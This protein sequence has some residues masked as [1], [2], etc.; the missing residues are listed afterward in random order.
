[1]LIA[2][3]IVVSMENERDSSPGD[4]VV[5]TDEEW[6]AGRTQVTRDM[7]NH[8]ARYRTPVFKDHGDHGEGWG[9]GSF[10]EING[11]KYILTNEHVATTRHSGARLGFQLADQDKLVLVQGDHVE[12]A[13]PLDLALLPVSEAGWTSLKHGSRAI[14]ADQIAAAHTA[15]P[16]EIF[17]F[18][19]FAGKGSFHFDTLLFRATTSVSREVELPADT[20]WDSRLHFGLDYRPDLAT[21]VVGNDGLPN[22]RGFSG[23]AVWN[24]R[25]VEAKI[26]GLD[27]TPDLA[28][29][30]GV[31]WGWPSNMVSS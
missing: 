25:Y 31:I 26:K 18:S 21:T 28:Q 14:Q 5:F 27:W 11:S 7:T 8:L 16:T 24:T 19:G 29:V 10:I 4:K 1:M 12:H 3:S 6:I 20:R 17:A 13:W 22:P 23:S 15:A 2:H 9:S 30:T